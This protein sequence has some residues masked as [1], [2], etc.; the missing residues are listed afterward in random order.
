M[1]GI[2]AL[3]QLIPTRLTSSSNAQNPLNS[4]LDGALNTMPWKQARIFEGLGY[5]VSIGA[6]TTPI[7]GGGNGTVYDPEQ[8][9]GVISVPV[10]R[11]IL[12]IRFSVQLQQPLLGADSEETEVLIAVDRLAVSTAAAGTGTVETIF[13]MRTDN[14]QASLC[15]AVSANT[16]DHNT[17]TLGLELARSVNVGDVNGTPGFAAFNTKHELVYEPDAPPLLVGPCAIYVYW[18]GTVATSGFA[19]LQWIEIPTP[20][21]S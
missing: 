3:R 10:G 6:I 12:P 14:P 8:S 15:T 16:S 7:V 2:F 21:V 5:H 13:N 20:P 19:Q 4:S 9:E 1:P 18:G 17:P 11:T